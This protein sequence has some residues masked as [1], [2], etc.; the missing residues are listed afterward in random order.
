MEASNA[1]LAQAQA[2]VNQGHF[3][4]L[5][6][7]SQLFQPLGGTAFPIQMLM[8]PTNPLLPGAQNPLHWPLMNLNKAAGV[9]NSF[10]LLSKQ[11]DDS[12]LCRNCRQRRC[13]VNLTPTAI[14]MISQD[15]NIINWEKY[16]NTIAP[17]EVPTGPEL[18]QSAVKRNKAKVIQALE[19]SPANKNPRKTG[20]RLPEGII[21]VDYLFRSNF[22]LKEEV[23]SMNNEKA[24]NLEIIQNLRRMIDERDKKIEQLQVMLKSHETFIKCMDLKR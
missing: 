16:P 12:C 24:I 5:L 8:A 18:Q 19:V 15:P 22:M 14:Q 2:L 10:C 20:R 11:P 21:N 13:G 23:K 17:L 4:A 3:Q 1:L 6:Q 7:H 9:S